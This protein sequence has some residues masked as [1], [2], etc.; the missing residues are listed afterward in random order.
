[1]KLIVREKIIMTPMGLSLWA[2][3]LA[4]GW[5]LPNH[6]RPWMAFHFDAWVALVLSV[7]S[8]TVFLRSRQALAWSR[9]TLLL[10]FL[11][12]MLWLQYALGLVLLAGNVWIS[13]AYLLGLLL[14]LLTGAHWEKKT[15]GQLGDGLFLAIGLAAIVSVGLQ[16]RQWLALDGLELWTMDGG[17]ER[18]FAN[19]GQPNQLGTFLLWGVLATAWGWTRQR[20]GSGVAMLL[21]AYLLF[22]VALTGSRTAWVGLALMVGAVWWWRRL[23]TSPRLTWA[24]TGLWLYFVVCTMSQG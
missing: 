20:I 17:P 22:G 5:L 15:P 6:Y 21:A 18:P 2:C 4:I 16:L 7:A 23:W 11:L 12:A 1:M 9:I 24:V 19:F 8:L 10:A 14:A 3:A 13:S